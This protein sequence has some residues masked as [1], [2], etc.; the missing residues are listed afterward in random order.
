MIVE[1]ALR[2]RCS[3][4]VVDGEAVSLGVDGVSDFN[5]SH[6]RQHND[7]VQLYA[8][9]ILMLDGED[10]RK[11]RLHFR[12]TNFWNNYGTQ[13]ERPETPWLSVR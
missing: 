12:K 1:A 10:V 2:N 7:E 13:R 4:F 6:S 9:D 5:G 8:F 11:L 3:S